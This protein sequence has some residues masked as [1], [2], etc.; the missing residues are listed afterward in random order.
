[1]FFI[2]YETKLI[3]YKLLSMRKFSVDVL[4]HVLHLLPH[5]TRCLKIQLN[6][7]N[8]NSTNDYDWNK[9]AS[10]FQGQSFFGNGQ[11]QYH[12]HFCP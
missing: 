5:Q 4:G 2:C 12:R 8:R 6:P 9:I 3:Q 10:G 7:R 1:M 11:L